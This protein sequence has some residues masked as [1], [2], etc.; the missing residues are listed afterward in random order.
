MN[1][2]AAVLCLA[3]VLVLP[4]AAVAASGP[5]LRVDANTATEVELE[6]I[7]G[8]GPAIAARIAQ[9]RRKAP[10]RSLEDLEQ[11][12]RGVGPAS[13]Q[14]MREGGLTVGRSQGPGEAEIFV[15]GSGAA[16]TPA[17]R[18]SRAAP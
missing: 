6:T 8:I 5:V 14:R 17:R 2:R 3:A 1:R 4:A 11:R 9:E 13:L 12:V 16:R 15:G 7:P 18:R 10:F